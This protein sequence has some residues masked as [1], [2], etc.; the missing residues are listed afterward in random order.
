MYNDQLLKT[1]LIIQKR[2][3]QQN[4]GISLVNV[5]CILLNFV[6]KNDYQIDG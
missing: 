1:Q 3:L 2:I 4:F 6:T 5:L